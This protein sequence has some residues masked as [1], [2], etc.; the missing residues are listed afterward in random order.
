MPR[1]MSELQRRSERNVAVVPA[2]GELAAAAEVFATHRSRNLLAAALEAAAGRRSAA[3][4]TAAAHEAHVLPHDLG[5]VALLTVL[6]LPLARTQR[7][8]DEHFAALR[9]VLLREVRLLA[10]QHDT[11]PF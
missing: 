4:S 8:F 7:A 3:C 6:V 2:A 10:E 1:A 11:V 5:R 9:Q